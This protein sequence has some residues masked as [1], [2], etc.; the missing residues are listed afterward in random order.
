MREV[1]SDGVRK[2]G[3]SGCRGSGPGAK[4]SGPYTQLCQL[5]QAVLLVSQGPFLALF[6]LRLKF[7]EV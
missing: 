5:T 4:K 1:L 6:H 7:S 3:D 2:L